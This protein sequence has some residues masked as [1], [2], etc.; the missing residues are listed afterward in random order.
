MTLNVKHPDI[1][2]EDFELRRDTDG[3]PRER[4]DWDKIDFVCER[5]FHLQVEISPALAEAGILTLL[6]GAGDKTLIQV[7][8]AGGHMSTS[9]YHFFDGKTEVLS[10]LGSV[11]E[12]VLDDADGNELTRRGVRLVFERYN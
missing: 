3:T 1:L 9:R 2:P 7:F 5:R 12:V 4:E 8:S 10:I 11:R 6:N